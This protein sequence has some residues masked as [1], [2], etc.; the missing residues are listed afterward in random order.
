MNKRKIETSPPNQFKTPTKK[1]DLK[2]SP[3]TTGTQQHKMSQI[4]LESLSAQLTALTGGLHAR[5]DRIDHH[6]EE[7]KK[8]KEEL[9]TKQ[10]ELESRVDTLERQLKRNNITVSG[11]HID[12]NKSLMD[13]V[14]SFFATELGKEITP[15]ETYKVQVKSSKP[16]I[17]VKLANWDDKMAI[18]GAK[19]TLLK[20]KSPVFINS[21]L[22]RKEEH[23]NFKARSLKKYLQNQG[24]EVKIYRQQVISG[25]E[26]YIFD[27]TSQEYV[28]ECNKA[29]SRDTPKN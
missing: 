24:K 14:K 18:M 28:K 10:T 22:T 13:N 7:W 23:I 9:I 12:E 8:E 26:I 17:I 2:K 4:T 25:N 3:T 29:Q 16:K 15:V 20:A 21:D 6:L 19:K 27:T 1:A 11:I 5:L